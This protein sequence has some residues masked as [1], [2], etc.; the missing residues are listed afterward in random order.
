[1]KVFN[2]IFMV[3]ASVISILSPKL[4]LSTLMTMVGSIICFYF[5]YLLPVKMHMKCLY[6]PSKAK[7]EGS[8]LD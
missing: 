7:E 1:M 6:P 2:I 4:P 3:V 5:I 8:V